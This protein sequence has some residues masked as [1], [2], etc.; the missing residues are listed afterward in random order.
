MKFEKNGLELEF[1]AE[2]GGRIARLSFQGVE[3]IVSPR[4]A[5]KLALDIDTLSDIDH[6]Q[7]QS[8]WPQAGGDFV[9]LS[10]QS[11]WPHS[12][13][14]AT[15]NLAAYQITESTVT[16]GTEFKLTSQKCLETKVTI[17]RS[18]GVD[19]SRHGCVCIQLKDALFAAPHTLGK[20][21]AWNVSQVLRCDTDVYLWL[22]SGALQGYDDVFPDSS[23]H[24]E[25]GVI[26]QENGWVYLN[27]KRP[28]DYKWGAL[29]V[30]HPKLEGRAV[31]LT[32]RPKD[33][34]ESIVWLRSFPV[35]NDTHNYAHGNSVEFCRYGSDDQFNFVEI[36]VHD[37]KK[38]LD[39]K[40][41][42]CLQQQ[43]A[44]YRVDRSLARHPD[45]LLNV[46]LA[47]R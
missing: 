10:P 20:W 16:N 27:V 35:V 11:C 46:F 4:N 41:L 25:T 42:S 40:S 30:G 2:R 47:Y 23:K 13:P 32:V 28:W 9:W 24:L 18:I 26:R 33:Q 15:L 45:S 1:A 8:D 12:N 21:T 39:Q 43:W 14:P 22:P 3:F 29:A 37:A 19:T 6:F 34:K 5:Q 36:E 17:E 31:V 7:R 38:K 44:F